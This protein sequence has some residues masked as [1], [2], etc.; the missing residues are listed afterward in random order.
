MSRFFS[1]MAVFVGLIAV[2]PFAQALGS[3]QGTINTSLSSVASGGAGVFSVRITGSYTTPPDCADS[4]V[5]QFSISAETKAGK[6]IIATLLM[7]QAGN[8]GVGIQGAGTCNVGGAGSED[9]YYVY[10]N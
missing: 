9:I 7:A 3:I 4:A 5:K 6:A 1:T 2:T 8:R 10:V